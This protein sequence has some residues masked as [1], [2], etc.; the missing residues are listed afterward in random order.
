MGQDF[1]RQELIACRPEHIGISGFCRAA[2]RNRFALFAEDEY[3][4][5]ANVFIIRF[6][7]QLLMDKSE[8]LE[9]IGL[10]EPISEELILDRYKERF[11]YFRMLY[12]NAPNKVIERIQQRNLEKLEEVKRVLLEAI[13]ARQKVLEQKFGAAAIPKPAPAPVK[14]DSGVAGW[15]IVHT[16]QRNPE[17]YELYP[18]I[19]FIG[20]K[21]RPDSPYNIII[22][23]D[24]YVS[25]THAFVKCKGAGKGRHFELY[26]G[27]GSKPSANGVFVN[28]NS[29]RIGGQCPIQDGDTIQVGATKLVFKERK[30]NSTASGELAEVL[31]TGFVRTV[32]IK[33]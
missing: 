11:Y 32:D 15:L 8:A 7:T 28:G 16:E 31:K 26:D 3:L 24:P 4:L 9:F 30:E 17:T 10:K 19:N 5:K 20:R 33:K 22:G 1:W 27:D 2:G 14:E 21:A 29:T 12:T 23:H 6:L 18:G 13:K 25:R